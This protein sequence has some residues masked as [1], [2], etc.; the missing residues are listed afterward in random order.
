MSF[1]STLR[2]W[3]L[4]MVS[5]RSRRNAADKKRS[6]LARKRRPLVES[7]EERLPTGAFF[8]G[9]GLSAVHTL[10]F[11]LTL[12]QSS[13]EQ[14]APPSA[15]ASAP[16]SIRGLASEASSVRLLSSTN[17]NSSAAPVTGFSVSVRGNNEISNP[18]VAGG[19]G[20]GNPSGA[21]RIG[22]AAPGGVT[23]PASSSGIS[24]GDFGFNSGNVPAPTSNF[25]SGNP[26]QDDSLFQAVSAMA[27]MNHGAVAA[28]SPLLAPTPTPPPPPPPPPP[29]NHVREILTLKSTTTTG[30]TTLGANTNA[31][32]TTIFQ[33][34]G[35]NSGGVLGLS[36]PLASPAPAA[37]QSI[38][39]VDA[40]NFIGG[41]GAQEFEVDLAINPTN[42]N[43]IVLEANATLAGAAVGPSGGMLFSTSFDG[44][45]TW[46]ARYIAT[47]A[48]GFDPACCDPSV[49]FDG[50]GTLYVSYFSATL[51]HA[52]LLMSV[53]GGKTLTGLASFGD[54][55]DQPKIAV[56]HNEIW[57]VFT[58]TTTGA[59][60]GF[61]A[62]IFGKGFLTGFEDFAAVPN[63]STFENFGKIAIGPKGQVLINYQTDPLVGQTV[64]IDTIRTSICSGFGTTTG[65][66]PERSAVTTRVGFVNS[67]PPVI[68]DRIS[69]A[70]SGVAYDRSN[71]PHSGR[72]YL[73]YM[74]RANLTTTD[75]EVYV[76]HSDDDG[77][78]WSAPVRVANDSTGRPKWHPRI[79]VDPT[80]GNVAV[81]WYDARNDTGSGNGDLDGIPGDEGEEFIGFS[82]DGGNTF[83]NIQVS[84]HASSAILNPNVPTAANDFGDYQALDFYGGVAH[85]AWTDNSKDLAGINTDAPNSFDI[86]TAAVNFSGGGGGGGGG[87]SED[88]YEPNDSSTKATN[89]GSLSAGT[90][91]VKNLTITIH[92]NGLPDRDWFKWTMASGSTFKVVETADSTNGGL[93]LHLFKLVNGS[94]KDMG[95]ATDASTVKTLSTSVKSNDVIYVEAKGRNFA[96]G[97]TGTGAYHLDITLS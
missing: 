56:A 54:A 40:S 61:G 46:N 85:P 42:P 49:A 9:F 28:F 6:L 82:S 38:S 79:A 16:N 77:A 24:A 90:Q 41:P 73:V 21:D 70:K 68:P 57:D 53:D 75:Y 8:S 44:G 52:D 23:A 47:G 93:E 88:Q 64:P 78:T 96:P 63:P 26:I 81:S 13:L 31:P 15:A 12:P 27:A 39:I 87:L 1:L 76:V 95:D 14:I 3:R 58:S 34:N 89:F 17:Q 2:V 62:G 43:N 71:G 83:S 97:Q 7:L 45:K 67:L 80:T 5:S 86:A 37:A 84:Q 11:G 25:G 10:P 20:L 66:S 51:D 32:P 18:P 36:A 22:L 94:L 59:M 60:E 91:H 50:F 30:H 72:A 65:F 92:S 48:D 4:L 29:F 55:A 74:D 19:A 35:G 33:G 69:D